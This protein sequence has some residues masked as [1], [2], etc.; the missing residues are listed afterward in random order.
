MQQQERAF[1]GGRGFGGGGGRTGGIEDLEERADHAL[2]AAAETLEHAAERI[3]RLADRIPRKGVGNR[4]GAFGHSTAD[5]LESVARFLRDND[6]ASLQ[7]DLGRLVSARPLS[8]L[9]IAVGA[10]FV[11]GKI[12]R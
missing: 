11:V 9:L 4:A 12:L 2:E 8:M 6:A 1:G 10:G 3:E 5:T 7:R